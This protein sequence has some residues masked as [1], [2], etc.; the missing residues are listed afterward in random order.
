MTSAK[1]FSIALRL[2]EPFGVS[3]PAS[4]EKSRESTAK[5]TTR[6]YGAR[7]RLAAATMRRR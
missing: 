4:K 1:D 3:S 2:S 6:S 5:S 7:S